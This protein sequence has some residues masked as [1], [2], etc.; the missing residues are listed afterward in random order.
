ML[1]TMFLLETTGNG[2]P[3][4]LSA[5]FPEACAEANWLAEE[6]LYDCATVQLPE[7]AMYGSGT[8]ADPD[9]PLYTDFSA[10]QS[11]YK[12]PV[13]SIE[14][15]NRFLASQDM[16]PLQA[17]N[18]PPDLEQECFLG[19]RIFRDV[20]KED[21]PK[22]EEEYGRLLVKPGRRPKLFEAVRSGEFSVVPN[23]EPLFVSQLFKEAIVAE[24]RVFILRGRILD[25]RP[26]ILTQWVCPDRGIVDAM[27]KA[28]SGYAALALDVAVLAGGQTVAIE[29]HPF[30]A[31]GQYGFDG[32]DMIRMAKSAWLAELRRQGRI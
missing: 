32:P 7:I 22:L 30:I 14:F 11:K 24:W 3:T 23:N 1:D 18:I 13:G 27:A 20:S 5:P 31:C 19:R 15:V 4:S 26:Y 2:L 17:M 10:Q 21:L 28:L 16:A 25:L 12:V 6:L 9:S 29:S 8:T